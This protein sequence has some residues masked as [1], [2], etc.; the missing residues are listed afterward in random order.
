MPHTMIPGPM[1]NMLIVKIQGEMNVDDLL[2]DLHLH[3][4][5]KYVLFD[6]TQAAAS[7]PENF[8]DAARNTPLKHPNFIHGAIVIQSQLLKNL[9]VVV[10]KLTRVRDKV[11]FFETYEEGYNHL[12]K[13]V[14][15]ANNQV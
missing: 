5:P 11:S 9:A 6:L 3:E 7:V 14:Q 10:A 1:P 4:G 8:W 13:L 2:P 12:L 15:Q